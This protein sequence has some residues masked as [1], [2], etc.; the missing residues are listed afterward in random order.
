MIPNLSAGTGPAA[1]IPIRG[2]FNFYRAPIAWDYNAVSWGGA[3]YF[4]ENEILG[5]SA[6]TGGSPWNRLR[7]LQLLGR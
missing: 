4:L 5:F 6:M 2:G 7:W 1:A 3:K